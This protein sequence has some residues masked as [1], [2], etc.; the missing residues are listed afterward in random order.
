MTIKNPVPFS[1]MVSVEPLTADDMRAIQQAL[2]TPGVDTSQ[3]E[4][5]IVQLIAQFRAKRAVMQA[6]P[7]LRTQQR[8]ARRLRK[9]H[10]KTQ[11][12]PDPQAVPFMV[13]AAVAN[14]TPVDTALQAYEQQVY[15][16][17]H[18][19]GQPPRPDED[20][21]ILSIYNILRQTGASREAAEQN[22]ESVLRICDIRCPVAAES[23]GDLG[24]MQRVIRRSRKKM[25][26]KCP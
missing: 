25:A 13:K 7:T 17:R 9:H 22:T 26:N 12:L 18:T 20:A 2:H 21:L 10:E 5:E 23:V 24:A 11:A 8:Y 19:P 1:H 14:G 15:A 3:Y 6:L 4:R 16:T